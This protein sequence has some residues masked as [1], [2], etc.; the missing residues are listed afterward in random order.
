MKFRNAA[1][2]DY[3]V[4]HDAAHQAFIAFIKPFVAKVVIVDFSTGEFAQIT[5]EEVA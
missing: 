3:Y 5:E 4:K 2:R 1:D